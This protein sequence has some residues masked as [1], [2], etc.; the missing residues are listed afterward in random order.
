MMNA[1][2]TSTYIQGNVSIDN[3]AID[4]ADVPVKKRQKA[5]GYDENKPIKGSNIHA[6]VSGESSPP[7]NVMLGLQMSMILGNCFLR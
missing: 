5:I 4:N 3:V 2:I 6:I 1:M 7:I